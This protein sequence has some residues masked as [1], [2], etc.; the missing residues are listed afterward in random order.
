MSKTLDIKKEPG[1]VLHWQGTCLIKSHKHR[2]DEEDP[3]DP[4]SMEIQLAK[5]MCWPATLTVVV[6]SSNC[7]PCENCQSVLHTVKLLLHCSEKTSLCESDSTCQKIK[8][9]CRKQA[10]ENDNCTWKQLMFLKEKDKHLPSGLL[11][12]INR[13]LL[14]QKI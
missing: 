10:I 9:F 12:Q 14:R 11:K 8:S 2:N 6:A 13:M 4:G 5:L 3:W 1:K 7:K